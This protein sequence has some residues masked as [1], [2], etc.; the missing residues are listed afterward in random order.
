[1]SNI[2]CSICNKDFIKPHYLSKYCSKNCSEKARKD[3]IKKRNNNVKN[4]PNQYKKKLAGHNKWL[5]KLNTRN[6][7][8]KDGNLL[9][10]QQ[11]KQLQLDSGKRENIIKDIF[12]LPKVKKLDLKICLIITRLI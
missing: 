2:N 1:M 11:V 8:D 12:L 10:N 4:N 9:T 5:K 7:I 6:F 3:Y